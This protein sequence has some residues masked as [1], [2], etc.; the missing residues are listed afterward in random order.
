[1]L[2]LLTLKQ[3]RLIRDARDVLLVDQ[4]AALGVDNPELDRTRDM[5]R[6]GQVSATRLHLELDKAERR[7]VA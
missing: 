4:L 1:M 6:V 2:G 5:L 3:R 7:Q